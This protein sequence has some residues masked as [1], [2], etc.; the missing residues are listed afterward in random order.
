[1]IC[2]QVFKKGSKIE[3]KPV[4]KGHKNDEH[5]QSYKNI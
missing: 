1:M 3:P 5:S 4:Y 2:T